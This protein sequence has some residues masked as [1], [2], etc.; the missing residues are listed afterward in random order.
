LR[1]I[2]LADTGPLYA[3]RDPDDS[4]H[5]RSQRELGRLRSQNLKVVVPYPA[6][7]EGYT[8]VMRELGIREAHGFLEEVVHGSLFENPSP[9]DY[10]K[11]SLRVLRYEDQDITLVDAVIAEIADRLA[12]PVWT[13]D[14]HFDVMRVAVWR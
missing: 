13:F 12:A 7:L 4:Q 6:L 8:L 1:G 9:E 10:R 2:V 5:E 14:H 3:A 11:A